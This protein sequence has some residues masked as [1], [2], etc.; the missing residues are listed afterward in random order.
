[1]IYK[2]CSAKSERVLT[3]LLRLAVQKIEYK[4]T[5]VHS[6]QLT[7]VSLVRP[8]DSEVHGHDAED[9]QTGKE[10]HPEARKTCQQAREGWLSEHGV[11]ASALAAWCCGEGGWLFK[12]TG[13]APCSTSCFHL[14]TSFS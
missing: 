5:L 14:F 13:C 1:M 12:D 10:A 2:A 9:R 8:S 3:F 11:T 4:L 7:L 6:F